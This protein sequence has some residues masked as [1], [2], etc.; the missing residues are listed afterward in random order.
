MD[1]YTDL[2]D[3]LPIGALTV[4]VR[5]TLLEANLAA[6][7]L[8]GSS[9]E[10]LIGSA[11]STHCREQDWPELAAHLERCARS[12]AGEVLLLCLRAPG[13]RTLDVQLSSRRALTPAGAPVQIRMG[14]TDITDLKR[15]Q[16]KLRETNA[17]QE[18][19][20][21]SISH[22]LRAPLITITNYSEFLS[23]EH[24]AAMAPEA[25]DILARI[26]RAAQR[27]DAVLQN[28]LVYSRVCRAE[29]A[30]GSVDLG[31]L[32]TETLLQHHGIIED[33]AA[34]IRVAD[35]F[36]MVTASRDLLNQVLSNLLTNALK[37][38]PKGVPPEVDIS[39]T[40]QNGDVRITVAD[41]GIGIAA[42]DH[43]RIFGMFERLHGQSSY[44]GTGIG[45]AVVR[46]A[47][48]RMSGRI[49]VE[50]EIG[51]GSRFH[52]VLPSA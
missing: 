20:T 43:E 4:D 8:L 47:V 7:E 5:G 25:R 39:A 33:C 49:W 10:K 36:P 2:Y 15:A 41:Q 16:D 50:S 26:Q 51:A 30:M 21:H 12:D 14:V 29:M 9:R 32:I 23:C 6:A 19:F 40:A 46:R 3:S 27:M 34:K 45:L 18:A 17:E 48:E 11:L 13:G 35:T 28:L 37:Y 1:R 44:P 42:Q 52:V 38:A 24:G 22:D 31:N